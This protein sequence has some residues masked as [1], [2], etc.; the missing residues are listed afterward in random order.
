MKLSNKWM[1]DQMNEQSHKQKN[2]M[3]EQK[4]KLKNEWMNEKHKSVRTSGTCKL[5]RHMYVRRWIE[6]WLNNP[7]AL[8][9]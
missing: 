7:I 9:R 6:C 4:N 8:H 3:D 5:C 2:H 1:N